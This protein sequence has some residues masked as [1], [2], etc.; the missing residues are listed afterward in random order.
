MD[1]HEFG[2]EFDGE[3]E[4]G[5]VLKPLVSIRMHPLKDDWW[6]SSQGNSIVSI[7]DLINSFFDLNIAGTP[8]FHLFFKNNEYLSGDFPLAADD[9]SSDGQLCHS[10]YPDSISMVMKNHRHIRA[11]RI[12]CNYHLLE[13]CDFVTYRRVNQLRST[14]EGASVVPGQSRLFFVFFENR[15]DFRDVTGIYWK[16]RQNYYPL[17][18]C[19]LP[20]SVLES[21]G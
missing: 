6:K 9:P 1:S 2:W 3:R 15:F 21:V 18:K 13:N 5:D 20:V 11:K 17:E 19:R 12:F 10:F 16:Y 8:S 7:R 4:E 14:L